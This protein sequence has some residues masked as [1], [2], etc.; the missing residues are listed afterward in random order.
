MIGSLH[1]IEILSYPNGS[2]QIG[3]YDGT[4]FIFSLEDE[5]L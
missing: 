5:I 3:Y 1:F 2:Y 4:F